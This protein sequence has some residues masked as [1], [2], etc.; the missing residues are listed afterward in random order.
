MAQTNLSTKQ[1]QT[2]KYKEKTCGCQGGGSG[3]DWEF[4]I[5]SSKLLHTGWISN[6]VL[7]YRQGAISNL[8]GQTMME[9]NIKKRMYGVPAVAQRVKNPTSIYEDVCLIPVSLSGLK[10]WRCC[11][12][13]RRSTMRLRS[14]TVVA[15]G[16][17]QRLWL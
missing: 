13:R 10:I 4:G 3:M 2:H 5:S 6:T 14:G 12:L 11:K 1:K 7:Q 9:E 15:C 16:I 17:G 8:L